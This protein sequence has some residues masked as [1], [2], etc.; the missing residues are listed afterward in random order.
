MTKPLL[1]RPD[2]FLVGAAKAG[3]TSLFKYVIQHPQI[4]IPDI[5]EPHYFSDFVQPRAPRFESVD[6]YLRLFDNCPPA[7][8]AGDASTS[9]LYSPRAAGR[10]H[11]LNPAARILM[12]LR[13]PVDRAYSMYWYNRRELAE[14]LSFEEALEAEPGRLGCD[15]PFRYHYVTSGKYA[16]QVHRYLDT[17]GSDAVRIYL[18]EDLQHDAEKLCRDIFSFLGVTSGPELDTAKVFNPG[19]PVRNRLLAWALSPQFPGREIIRGAFPRLSRSMKHSLLS[20]NVKSPPPM[21]TETANRLRREFRE[22][23][24]ELETLIARDLSAW[25]GGDT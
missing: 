2:F 24:D 19:G 20:I 13:D 10:I 5:K 15:T 12:I 7:S 14:D 4:F 3:T 9:Y 11:E 23:I 18:F 22:D 6:D 17:F 16:R 25:K 1:K 21:R 8:V